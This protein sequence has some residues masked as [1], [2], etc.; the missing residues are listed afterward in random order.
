MSKRGI[1]VAQRYTPVVSAPVVSHFALLSLS[2]QTFGDLA[3]ALQA[4]FCD[5]AILRHQYTALHGNRAE[6]LLERVQEVVCEQIAL[7]DSRLDW[8]DLLVALRRL[9]GETRCALVTVR[10]ICGL[11]E[12]GRLCWLENPGRLVCDQTG[13]YWQF[14]NSLLALQRSCQAITTY[15][16]KKTVF[17]RPASARAALSA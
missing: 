5:L 9:Y 11:A 10:S 6:R 7:L 14:G 12:T 3:T 2:A 16:T 1:M 15:L 8:Q 17:D 13:A 4:A